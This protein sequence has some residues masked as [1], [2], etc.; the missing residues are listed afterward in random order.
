M[1]GKYEKWIA[2]VFVVILFTIPGTIVFRFKNPCLTETE[3]LLNYI[4]AA[5]FIHKEFCKN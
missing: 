4:N 5:F 2:I 3:L 1:I